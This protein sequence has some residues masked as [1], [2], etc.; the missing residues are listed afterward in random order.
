MRRAVLLC[1]SVALAASVAGSAGGAAWRP[2]APAAKATS[3]DFLVAGIARGARVPIRL[4]PGGRV[5]ARLGDRTEFGSAQR[6]AV[7]ETRDSR[8]LAVTTP[9]LRNGRVAWIDGDSRAVR[10]SRVRRAIDI[11]LSRRELRVYAGERLL[12]TIRVAVGR[13]GSTT[14]TGRFHVTDK[15]RGADF[16]SYYGC[17]ILALSGRQTNLPRGWTGGNR[18]AI[19]GTS[20]PGGIGRA[21]SAG[22]LHATA[23]QLRYLMRTIGLGTPVFIH[24]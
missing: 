22:C 23:A 12:R 4:R 3:G 6:V 7:V 1:L 17:C 15:L 10:L 9:A 5:V 13:A 19:H 18:L 11:D 16:G 2:A 21:R 14:P 20:S 24:A 8:W